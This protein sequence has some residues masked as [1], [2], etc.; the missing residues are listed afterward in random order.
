M[1]LI[2][3]SFGNLSDYL[4]SEYRKTHQPASTIQALITQFLAPHLPA[5]I[6]YG[7]G[8]IIDV[9][10]RE[11]GPFDVVG[12]LDNY[13]A[14]GHGASS[15][16]VSEGV[17]FVIQARN[18]AEHDLTQFGAVADQLKSLERKRKPAITCL[19]ISYEL[20]PLNEIY[21]FLSGPAGKSIDGILCLGHH[22]VL[23]NNHGLY[24]DPTRVPFV[25]EH[26]GP[27]ALKALGFSLMHLTQS[28]LNQ[29]FGL[30]DYQHL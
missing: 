1:G 25:T 15:V 13:P 23:R 14:F 17:Q 6:R 24:G 20:L 10:E 28:A 22:I 11:V 5:G 27:E 8:S 3:E 30:A 4:V 19:A 29:T 9:R 2:T 18:W 12:T 16:Y 26:P 7:S 21:S